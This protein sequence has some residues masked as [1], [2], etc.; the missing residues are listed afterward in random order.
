MGGA[1]FVRD[2]TL[3]PDGPASSRQTYTLVNAGIGYAWRSKGRRM[4]I[5]LMGKNLRDEKYRPSQS[6][7]GRPREFLLTFVAGF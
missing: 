5:D 4:S 2:Q 7:R 1:N 6:T 3:L